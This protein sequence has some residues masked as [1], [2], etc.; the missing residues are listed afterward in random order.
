MPNDLPTSMIIFGASGDLSQRK[1]LPSLLN[2]SI[3]GRMPK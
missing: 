1:L 2:L 3:K